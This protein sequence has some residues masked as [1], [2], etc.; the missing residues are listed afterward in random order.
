MNKTYTKTLRVR[1]RDKHAKLLQQLAFECNQVWNEANSQSAEYSWVPVPGVG[2][3]NFE[4]SEFDLNK[5]LVRIRKERNMSIGAVTMQ[6]VI[7]QHAKS[8]RQFNKNKLK[9]RCSSGS[10][11]SLGWIPF[12]TKS[13]KYINGQIR[14]CGYYFKIWD[15]Y[16][17]SKYELGTGCFSEDSRGRWYFN[18]TI[19]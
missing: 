9:F 6:S 12:K 10:K 18:T 17:L 19:K 7:A 3:M 13:I 11:R 1:V 2:Y 16:N 14:F 8:H 15:S 4:T 5:H